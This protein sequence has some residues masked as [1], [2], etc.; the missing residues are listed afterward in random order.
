MWAGEKAGL[1]RSVTSIATTMEW[2]FY[3]ADAFNQPLA[4]DGRKN[5][6]SLHL[7]V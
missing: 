3:C 5:E 6:P 7:R 2:T 1:L 4:G